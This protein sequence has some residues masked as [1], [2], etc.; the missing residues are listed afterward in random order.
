ISRNC[1]QAAAATQEVS[2]SITT[3]QTAAN[4]TDGSAT[5]VLTASEEL[6]QRS[7]SLQQIVQTFLQDVRT[8]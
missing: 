7:T 1:E 2:S 8:A 6:A 4:D 3:V 5:E